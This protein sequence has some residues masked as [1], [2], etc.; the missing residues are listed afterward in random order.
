M[1]KR[2]ID[3]ELVVKIKTHFNISAKEKVWLEAMWS[4]MKTNY[5][6]PE[7]RQI[8]AAT[9][10]KT[11]SSFNPRNIDPVLVINEHDL[12]IRFLGLILINPNDEVF[13][14]G[15]KLILEVRQQMLD[16]ADK[17]EFTLK[18]LADKLKIDIN[19]LN[20]SFK[21]FSDFFSMKNSSGSKNSNRKLIQTD[22]FSVSSDWAQDFYLSFKDLNQSI[23][24]RFQNLL[25]D[26]KAFAPPL[27][28]ENHLSY[29]NT[30]ID[31]TR[32]QE[33][34]KIKNSNFDLTKLIQLTKEIEWSFTSGNY[35]ST[36]LLQRAMID[37]IPPLFNCQ[38]FNEVVNNYKSEGNQQSFKKSMGHLHNSLRAIGDSSIHSQI[39]KKEVLT[40][41]KQ[42]D[43]SSDVDV[44][45]SE[46]IRILK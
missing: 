11:D 10:S 41:A 13:S 18:E 19:K 9:V 33:L 20:L 44:L 2:N 29:S 6:F 8:R 22:F 38:N 27:I 21:I 7:Y 1:K 35:Y 43:F 40:N 46:I 15:L 23:W 37:H 16:D 32:L 31:Y 45:L 17:I 34:E 28:K 24:N 26:Q 30:F 14:I 39:R 36:A 5:S 42:V 25:N 12:H 3:H 4:F